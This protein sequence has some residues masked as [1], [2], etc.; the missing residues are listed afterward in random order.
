MPPEGSSTQYAPPPNQAPPPSA[1]VPGGMTQHL[2]P[3]N[4]NPAYV[5]EENYVVPVLKKNLIR[6][7]P[8]S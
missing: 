3:A 5:P 1:Q 4:P 6:P 7:K 2:L 8:G